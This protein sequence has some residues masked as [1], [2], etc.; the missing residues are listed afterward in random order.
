MELVD[1]GKIKC[2]IKPNQEKQIY[3]YFDVEK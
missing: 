2:V 3:E 1:L